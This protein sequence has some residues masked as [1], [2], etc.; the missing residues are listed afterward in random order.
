M[1]SVALRGPPWT[2]DV[3]VAVALLR[4][5]C[6]KKRCS[7][8]SFVVLRGQKVLKLK[9]PFSLALRGQ[10][11]VEVALALLRGPP[12]TKGVEVAVAVLRAPPWPSVVKG[13]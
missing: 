6:G 10:K 5:L 3:E 1:F 9:L 13:R 8:W 12:W 4:A 11:G 7:S 2:K